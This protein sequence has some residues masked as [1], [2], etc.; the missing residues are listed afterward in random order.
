MSVRL[1]VSGGRSP[2]FGGAIMEGWKEKNESN[3]LSVISN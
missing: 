3:W 2:A 1:Q